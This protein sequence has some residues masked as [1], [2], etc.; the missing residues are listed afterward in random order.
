MWSE[1]DAFDR[2]ESFRE[3]NDISSKGQLSV[4]VQVTDM[5]KGKPMPLNPDDFKTEKEGQV[6]GLGGGNLKKVLKRHGITRTL[7]SEGGRTSRGSMGLVRRYFEFLNDW[8]IEAEAVDFD[9]IEQYWADR[10]SDY[11]NS[12]PFALPADVSRTVSD[13]VN[14]LFDQARKRQAENPGTHY[15]GTV[16][17]HLVGAKLSLILPEGTFEIH[18]ASVADA[19]TGRAGDFIIEDTA[20]HCTTMPGELLM[21]KCA[22]NVRNGLHPVVVTIAE[23]TQVAL[24]LIEDKGLT[25]KAEVWD[26]QQFLSANVF[27]HSL[28]NS[29][30][31]NSFISQLVAKYNEIVGAVESDPSL[32]ISFE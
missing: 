1:Q 11:F 9:Y 2:L 24:S 26:A 13:C 7:A 22:A 6:K 5:A 17:Q 18:G 12:E 21:E 31:R 4:V 14:D 19:P 28:F 23:R 27:E 29:S 30:R 20:I 15:L 16:L 25:G 32:R 8:Q 10:V 3:D